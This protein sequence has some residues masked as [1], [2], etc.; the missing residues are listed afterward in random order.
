MDSE[1]SEDQRFSYSE[2]S[3]YEGNLHTNSKELQ[4]KEM[5]EMSMKEKRKS[6]RLPEHDFSE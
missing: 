4:K 1:N 2:N 6:R 3:E 5:M